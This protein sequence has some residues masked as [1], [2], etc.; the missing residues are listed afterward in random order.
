MTKIIS[1]IFE[2]GV[3]KPLQEVDVKEH[4][5]VEIKIFSRDEWQNRFNRIIEK[6][7]KKTSKYTSDEIEA[8]IAHAIKE[9]KA[10]KYG[11]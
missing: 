8:D 11:R 1:A 10:E 2:N 7:H 4:E 3:F 5:K 9:V 6:I